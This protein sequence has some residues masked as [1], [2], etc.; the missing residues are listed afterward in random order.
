MTDVRKYLVDQKGQQFDPHI[1]DEFLNYID[2]NQ[3]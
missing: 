2:E 1:V 3:E